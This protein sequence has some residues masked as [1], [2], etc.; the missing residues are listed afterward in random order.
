[1]L[2]WGSGVVA[3]IVRQTEQTQIVRIVNS[4]KESLAINYLD[5]QPELAVGQRVVTNKTATHLK[6]GTGGYDFI[7]SPFVSQNEIN[8]TVN[9]HKASLGHIMKLKYTPYQFSVE[10]C[11]EQGSAFHDLF[12]EPKTLAGLPVLVGELHSMLPIL[13]ALIR[14]LELKNSTKAKKIAY[15][16]TDGGALPIA[17][18]E[19]VRKLKSLG[20]LG[21]TITFGQSFGGDLE[22][23]NIYTALIAAKQI[24][25]A[26]LVIVTM[27]PGIVGT[28]TLLGHSGIEQGVITNAVKI[29]DGLPISLVRASLADQRVRHHGISHHTLTSLGLISLVETIIPYPANLPKEHPDLYQQLNKHFAKKHQLIQQEVDMDEVKRILN[30]YP[31]PI[32]TMGRGLNEDALFFE[33]V[34]SSAYLISDILK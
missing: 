32:T 16:M 27:G 13:V 17:I 26:D 23:I 15:I 2:K 25:N 14:G 30:S 24:C 7:I 29:L 33:F 9:H 22:A 5:F 12:R 31:L 18:S 1:M 8:Y 28:G 34:A 19:H 20:W 10:S 6:L 4:E 11:E 3:E 21:F